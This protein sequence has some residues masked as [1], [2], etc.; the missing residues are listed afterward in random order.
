MNKHLLVSDAKHFRV[1]YEI[2]PYMSTADQP[3]TAA[4][5]AEHKDIIEAHRE[6]GRTIE[7]VPSDP[8]CPDMVFTANAALV[9]GDR[10]VLGHPPAERATE[11]PHYRRWLR[12]R[13]FE[14]LEAPYPFSGQGDALPCGDLLLAG[15]GWRT[16]PRM[17]DFLRLRLGYEVVPLRTVDPRWYDL[18]LVVA[19]IDNPRTL[20][21]FPEALDLPSRRRVERLGLELVEVSRTEAQRFAL[22]LISDGEWVTMNDRAPE[23]AAELRRRGLQVVELTTAELSKGGGG[24]RCTALTLNQSWAPP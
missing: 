3:D 1:D 6:A 18:D 10:A 7:Y 8:D 13:G 24:V 15:S 2:N 14:V 19:P 22:N 9:C 20:A 23:L 16:D 11:I 4:A 17:H 12:R 5:V 21:W